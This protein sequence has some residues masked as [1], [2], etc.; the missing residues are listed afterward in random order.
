MRL[1]WI[2]LT[3]ALLALTATT[4]TAAPARAQVSVSRSPSSTSPVLGSVIRG[5]TTSTF[6]ISPSGVVT[7]TSGDAIRL[8]A[9]S[10]TGTTVTISCG[11]LNLVCAGRTLRVTIQATGATGS[12]TLTKF[13]VGSLSGTTYSAGS[14]PAEA[15]SLTFNLNGIGLLGSCSFALG[16]DVQVPSGSIT[17]SGA[18]TYS[19]TVNAL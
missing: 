19:I 9:V 8:S 15:S 10:V 14:A 11:L 12:A 5:S 18:Y 13:R 6:S 7:R 17:G 3:A 1:F 4:L 2:T 16:M